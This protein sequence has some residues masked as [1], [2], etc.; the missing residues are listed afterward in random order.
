MRRRQDDAI[1]TPSKQTFVKG[2]LLTLVMP[3]TGMISLIVVGLLLCRWRRRTGLALIWIG[4]I[5]LYLLATPLVAQLLT[6][7]LERGLP[8][9]PPPGHPPQAIVILGGEKINTADTPLGARPGPLTM[10]RLQTGAALARRTGLPILVTGGVIRPGST[11]IGP[12]MAE[13][14]TSDFGMPPRWIEDRSEDTWENARFSATILHAAGIDSV[15]LVTSAWHMRR[16]L[17]S[18]QGTGLFVTPAPTPLEGAMGPELG[19]LQ[20]HVTA[21]LSSYYA[22]HEWIGYV[23]YE[24]R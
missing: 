13:S 9:Q 11:A 22:L 24:L 17:L 6:G 4:A 15:Y 5:V 1:S 12:I 14:L 19:D 21:W 23:W 18:F 8:T 10:E 16:A 20:P 3:P 2:L 7:G